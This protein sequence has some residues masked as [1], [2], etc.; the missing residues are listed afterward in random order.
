MDTTVE[1][2]PKE[3]KGEMEVNRVEDR[4]C[5]GRRKGVS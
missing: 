1:T 5:E 4:S 3:M 2:Q